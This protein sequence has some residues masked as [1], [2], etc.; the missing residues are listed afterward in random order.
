MGS[1]ISA[2][3]E[4]KASLELSK[5]TVLLQTN[6][7]PLPSFVYLSL[8]AVMPLY[9]CQIDTVTWHAELLRIW[10]HLTVLWIQ[11]NLIAKVSCLYLIKMCYFLLITVI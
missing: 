10:I 2:L 11:R 9:S 5:Y 1:I 4:S 7:N 3:S 8:F 6:Q